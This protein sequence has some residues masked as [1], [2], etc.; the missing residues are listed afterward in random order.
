MLDV[1][2]VIPQWNREA[3]LEAV[4]VS[5]GNQQEQP[6]EVIVVDNG[7]TDGSVRCARSHGATVLELGANR[8][9]A[10]AVNEGWK[11]ARSHWVLVLNN[12]V[13]LEEG[14][15]E[16]LTSAAE[17]ARCWFAAP[18]LLTP[19]RD[20]VLDGTFDLMSR[21][22]TAWRAG[23]GQARDGAYLEPRSIL[24]PPLTAA[25][26]R[27]ELIERVGPLDERFGSYLEDVDFGLRCALA[28][29]HGVY[30]PEAVARHLG[31][32]TLGAWSGEMVRLI[33]RNQLLLVAKHYPRG[34]MRT[35][36]RQIAVAQLLWGAMAL[37]RGRGFAWLRGRLEGLR[38]YGGMRQQP[39]TADP[40]RLAEV[41]G[42]SE[43]QLLELSRKSGESYWRAYFWLAG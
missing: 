21:G 36:G 41:L 19:E 22:A 25:L 5:L 1:S 7:S 6:R 33:S 18:C 35:Y 40:V 27:R 34:W 30:V 32:A 43:K 8:G 39:A 14:F 31:S 4:L 24:F 11:Q 28:G 9:F 12:D 16:R 15:L 38:M 3:L 13:C 23:H 37:R 26:L 2:V 29:L 20:G 10:R 42:E 17:Q